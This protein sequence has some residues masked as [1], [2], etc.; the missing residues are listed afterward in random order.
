[1]GAKI[2][3]GIRKAQVVKTIDGSVGLVSDFCKARGSSIIR[4]TRASTKSF[5]FQY[6]VIVHR[7]P[8]E[9]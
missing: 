1:M 5:K 7:L 9:L 2:I 8:N 6:R 4:I 3:I